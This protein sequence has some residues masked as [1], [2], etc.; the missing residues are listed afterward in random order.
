MHGFPKACY[1]VPFG[2]FLALS[3]CTGIARNGIRLILRRALADPPA[4][5]RGSK[6]EHSRRD[7]SSAEDVLPRNC[8]MLRSAN[9]SMP[10]SCVACASLTTPRRPRLI[11]LKTGAA[12]ATIQRCG[13][14]STGTEL[15]DSPLLPPHNGQAQAFADLRLSTRLLASKSSPFSQCT[16]CC[17]ICIKD[18]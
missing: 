18:F 5:T 7:L 1:S 14:Y 16:A 3:F 13:R 10:I 11:A 17:R 4:A 15:D 8:P 2:P 6:A 9:H 12:S